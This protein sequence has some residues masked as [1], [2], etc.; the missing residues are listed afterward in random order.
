MQSIEANM[1]TVWR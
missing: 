1:S